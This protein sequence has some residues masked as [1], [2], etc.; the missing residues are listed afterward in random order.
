M[1]KGKMSFRDAM[2]LVP[3]DLPDGA[4]FA[5]AHEIAGLDY[6]EGFYEMLDDE[7]S[8]RVE[9][10]YQFRDFENAKKPWTCNDCGKRFRKEQGVRDHY[11]DV[12]VLGTQ[13]E[14]DG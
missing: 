11:R 12:H 4:Y 3:D 9:D 10:G 5:M 6:G 1:G 13:G 2:D 7:V 8:E 14:N